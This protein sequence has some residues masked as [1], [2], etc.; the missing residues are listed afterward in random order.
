MKLLVKF[1]WDCGRQGDV[2]GLFIVEKDVL[3]KSYG[4]SVYFGEILGKHSEV[5]GTL[6]QGD[7][8][9]KSD[10]QEFIAKVEELLGSD[11]SGYNPFDYMQEGEPEEDED[12]E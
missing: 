10:D 9:V 4:K 12:G 8:T 7:I 11:L 6:D 2:D 1:R 5:Q 3:E